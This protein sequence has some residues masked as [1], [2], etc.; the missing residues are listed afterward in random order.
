MKYCPDCECE[1]GV[2][3][4]EP[5]CRHAIDDDNDYYGLQDIID[6]EYRLKSLD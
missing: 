1:L 2:E 4:H 5:Y 6:D 3:K